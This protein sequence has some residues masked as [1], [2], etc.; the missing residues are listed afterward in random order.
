MKKV[1][2]WRWRYRDA[3][4]GRI[5]RTMFQLTAEEAARYPEAERIEGTML[6][7]EVEESDFADTAPRVFRSAAAE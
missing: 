3:Q 2:Y 4:T 6:L 1:E 7:R 5:C